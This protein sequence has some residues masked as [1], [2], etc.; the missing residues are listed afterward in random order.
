[1]L[2]DGSL[3]S[4]SERWVQEF[5]RLNTIEALDK[6]KAFQVHFGPNFNAL[7]PLFRALQTFVMVSFHGYD[8]SRVFK[9]QGND[10]YEFL[11]RRAD[12][13]TT[14]TYAMKENLISKGCPVT[15]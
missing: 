3:T 9:Q 14:P 6:I 1:M 8:A 4:N 12:L 5:V 2:P 15:K 13:I 11:F 7:A 10:C